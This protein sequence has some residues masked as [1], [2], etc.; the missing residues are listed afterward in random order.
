LLPVPEI[1]I[2]VSVV[3]VKPTKVPAVVV[4]APAASVVSVKPV[5]DGEVPVTAETLYVLPVA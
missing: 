3:Y 5:T 2:T 1:S 4:N